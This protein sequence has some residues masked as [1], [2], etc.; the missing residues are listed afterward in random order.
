MT[1]YFMIVVLSIS[2]AI[3]FLYYRTQRGMFEENLIT[4]DKND[5]IYLIGNVEKQ[6]KL[7]E[8]LSD[9]LYVNRRIEIALVRDYVSDMNQYDRE[10]PP[11]NRLIEEQINSSSI[12][13]YLVFLYALGNNDISLKAMTDSYWLE[14]L[15]DA[16]WHAQGMAAGGKVIWPGIFDNPAKYQ[17]SRKIIPVT[18]SIIFADTR[19]Q[20]G[21]QVLAFSPAL[22]GD[23]FDDYSSDQSRSVIIID[24]NNRAVFHQNPEMI[25]E[26]VDFDFLDTIVNDD[27]GS[28]FIKMNGERFLVTSKKSAYS[29]MTMLLFHSLIGLEKET[30]FILLVLIMMFLVIIA[31]FFIL[32]YYLSKRLTEPLAG[33]MERLKVVSEGTFDMDE[34]ITGSDEMGLIGRGI[35]EMAGRINQLM[36]NLI[37]QEREKYELE[38]R[39]LLNQI[40][41]HFVYNVLNSIKVMADIQK[42][43]GISEMASSLGA[44]LKEISKGSN[45]LITIKRELELLEKYLYIQRI[46][47]RGLLK[48]RYDMRDSE[49]ILPCL[50][51]RFTLQMLAENAIYHG[52]DQGERIGEIDISISLDGD[53]IVIVL[54]DNGIGIAE[55]KINSMLNNDNTKNENLIQVGLL[56]VD[57]RIKLLF[58]SGGLT[59]ES[60]VGEFTKACI[61]FPRKEC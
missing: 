37:Q 15:T 20:I 32:T 22:I 53:D 39:V 57:K 2:S 19:V 1:W 33:I 45:E 55:E 3:S 18:R 13:K 52:I 51:P 56:N 12:G 54:R 58:G 43:E 21:W 46:S 36:E 35:N 28:S 26:L 8:K 17:S 30:N 4:I 31:M 23:V 42:I 40:N 38:Y 14:D 9:W 48:V 59:L 24:Q 27:T 6:L 49:V 16:P 61:R 34:T 11:I 7:C 29:G 10:I 25:G 60:K 5:I 44:L 50:I 47:R 41:P